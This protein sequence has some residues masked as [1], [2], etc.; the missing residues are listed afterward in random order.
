MVFNIIS[1]F[2]YLRINLKFGIRKLEVWIGIE[3]DICMVCV[4][5]LIFEFVVLS[6]FIG[7]IIFEEYV[8]KVFD[9]FWEKR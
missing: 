9:F 7:V 6:W 8:R 5:I 2:F 1:G 4:G 3:I